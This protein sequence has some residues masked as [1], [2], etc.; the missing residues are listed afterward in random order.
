MHR[1]FRDVLLSGSH[2]W[3]F[4]PF[5]PVESRQLSLQVHWLRVILDEGHMLGASLS[6]TNKLQMACALKAERRWVMTGTPVPQGPQA[7]TVA[8]LQ[9]LLAFL[10]HHPYG[11]KRHSWEVGQNLSWIRPSDSLALCFWQGPCRWR[12][13]LQDPMQIDTASLPFCSFVELLLQP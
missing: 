3:Q 8:H 4:Q 10:H 12:A 13:C 2:G 9:P 5:F 11:I 7:A 6:M 1:C